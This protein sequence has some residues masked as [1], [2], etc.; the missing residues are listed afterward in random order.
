MLRDMY[1]H[2]HEKCGHVKS[3]PPLDASEL[4][5]FDDLPPQW[6]GPGGYGWE[7]EGGHGPTVYY[8]RRVVLSPDG[9]PRQQSIIFSPYQP[10]VVPPGM[11]HAYYAPPTRHPDPPSSGGGSRE[12]SVKVDP[13]WLASVADVCGEDNIDQVLAQNMMIED[14]R[15][16]TPPTSP[17]AIYYKPVHDH[18]HGYPD[19]H[20]HGA[21]MDEQRSDV[22][23]MGRGGASYA[24]EQARRDEQLQ[25]DHE[26]ARRIYDRDLEYARKQAERLYPA[27]H[28]VYMGDE[29]RPGGS[30]AEELAREERER[31]KREREQREREERERAERERE[32]Q[33]RKDAEY[34]WQIQQKDFEYAYKR[35]ERFR[36][37]EERRAEQEVSYEYLHERTQAEAGRA[38]GGAYHNPDTYDVERPAVKHSEDSDAK[39]GQQL[40]LAGVPGESRTSSGARE[41][42]PHHPISQEEA[43]AKLARELHER[44]NAYV[45]SLGRDELMAKTLQEYGQ[46][47]ETPRNDT[48]YDA[49][50]DMYNVTATH[51]GQSETAYR[52]QESD[53]YS[54]A[55]AL[56]D[57]DAKLAQDLHRKERAYEESLERDQMLARQIQEEEEEEKRKSEHSEA[58]AGLSY[59]AS[60]RES[61]KP[62]S[63]QEVKS[64]AVMTD[65]MLARKLMMEDDGEEMFSSKYTSS[66]Q[67][68]PVQAP[69][70]SARDFAEE[71]IP[72]E[73]CNK[74]YSTQSISDHQVM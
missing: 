28:D 20:T 14:Y 33:E 19:D 54:H 26:F 12:D 21:L 63:D 9:T 13:Q 48:Y 59:H 56:Q 64:D 29:T 43:D 27:A 16:T 22:S 73:Y 37:E 7:A 50:A 42:A 60:H 2:Q 62:I 67:H 8:A 1:E 18:T 11:G 69:A 74:V 66:D 34:A 72:C 31:E 38:T 41:Q 35:G 23:G 71:V 52:G 47:S 70:T 32:E 58:I 68:L 30:V 10:G 5:Q 45:K 4:A 25:Q 39:L 61:Y 55:A 3:K 49:A 65:E 17:R 51:T 15:K 24:D 44:E 57:T 6:E 40:E 46:E 53:Y 36:E